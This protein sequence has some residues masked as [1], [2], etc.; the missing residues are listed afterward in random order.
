MKI[1]WLLQGGFLFEIANQR[2][3]VDAYLSDIIES[4]QKLT[5]L[6]T[7]PIPL[8]DLK[9]SIWICTHDHLYP[10]YPK[11]FIQPAINVF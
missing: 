9:P 6:A 1:T 3:V 2:I 7:P 5:R 8:E 4:R 11:K 10:V